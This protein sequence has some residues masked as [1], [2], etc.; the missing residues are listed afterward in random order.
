MYKT[1]DISQ[2]SVQCTENNEFSIEFCTMY[3][4]SKNVQLRKVVQNILNVYKI[5]CTKKLEFPCGPRWV[6]GP[7]RGGGIS[8]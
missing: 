2:N 6:K 7:G 1:T 4:F 8:G 3:K 5:K